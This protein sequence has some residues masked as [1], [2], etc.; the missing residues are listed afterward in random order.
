MK[1]VAVLMEDGAFALFFGPHLGDLP[2]KAKEMPMPG[3]HPGGEGAVG[4]RWNW[5]MHKLYT[6]FLLQILSIWIFLAT[7][8]HH[9][10]LRES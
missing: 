8:E 9:Q 6:Y 10:L 5:L 3:G 7:Q 1:N 4:C 2:S